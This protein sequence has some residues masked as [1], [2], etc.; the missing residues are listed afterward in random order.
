MPQFVDEGEPSVIRV[1]Y[2]GRTREIEVEATDR[3]QDIAALYH[4]NTREYAFYDE[5]NGDRALDVGARVSGL[6]G[7]RIIQNPKGA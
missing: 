7:L 6:N 3:V 1:T 5:D 4:L 2:D